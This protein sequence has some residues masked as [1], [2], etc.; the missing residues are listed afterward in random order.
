MS[1]MLEAL[2][3]IEAKRGSV[4]TAAAPTSDELPHDEHTGGSVQRRLHRYEQASAETRRVDFTD[5]QR[6]VLDSR[7]AV[8][9]EGENAESASAMA[10]S[11]M[12]T[13]DETIELLR[14]MTADRAQKLTADQIALPGAIS[15]DTAMDELSDLLAEAR[16]LDW[17]P[18]ALEPVDLVSLREDL[19]RACGADF[20]WDQETTSEIVPPGPADRIA[21]EEFKLALGETPAE[22]PY[23]RGAAAPPAIDRPASREPARHEV[24]IAG[25]P[26]YE[27]GYPLG[28]V[29]VFAAAASTPEMV[30]ASLDSINAARA[31]SPGAAI[32]HDAAEVVAEPMTV[33]PVGSDPYAAAAWQVLRQIPEGSSQVLLFTSPGDGHGKTTTLARL[34]PHVAR[35]FS[36]SV[37]V[38]DA[39]T[40]NP[41]MSRRLEVA[42]TWR[43]TDVLAGATHWMNA[44][45]PTALPRVSLLPGGTSTARRPNT[46]VTAALLRE[47]AGHYDLVLVDATS[48]AHDGAAQLA[49]ACDGTCLVVRLGEAG[50]R[51]VRDAVRVLSRCGGR[52][53][54]CIAIDAGM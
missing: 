2:K 25:G 53:L 4:R 44:V 33:D 36:G 50:R 34:L 15:L 11:A 16:L 7:C 3:R 42:A 1:L 22:S 26:D 54:G 51:T 14:E 47:L 17:R 46:N 41:D 9:A 27:T 43:L 23:A 6:A 19:D 30:R 12:A 20:S 49:A 39:N 37:L 48:L 13:S 28:A 45:R 52:L 32:V 10:V 38:I 18:P 40:R 24:Y 21:D 5:T 35:S 31:Q 29:E 8:A